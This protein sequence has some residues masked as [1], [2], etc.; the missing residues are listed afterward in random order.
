MIKFDKFSFGFPEKDLYEDVNLEIETGDH[1]VLIGSNGS[2][3]SSLINL[4]LHEEKYTYEGLIRM[5]RDM[6]IGYVSQFVE[7]ET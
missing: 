6:C 7:H 5:N 2:G 4:I 1:L 3:K